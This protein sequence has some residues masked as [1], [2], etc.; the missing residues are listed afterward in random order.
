MLIPCP[1]CGPRDSSEF[2]YSG[3]ATVTRPDA[4][5]TTIEDWSNYIYQRTNPVGVHQDYWHHVQGCRLLLKVTRNTLTHAVSGA[6]IV[7]AWQNWQNSQPQSG[8][9][10]SQNKDGAL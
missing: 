7:G 8:A 4:A 9:V 6:E 5:N 1:Y 2:T 10:N 3:D